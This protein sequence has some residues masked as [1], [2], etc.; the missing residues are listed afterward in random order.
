MPQDGGDHKNDL[1]PGVLFSLPPSGAEWGGAGG[2]H[3]L[4]APGDANEEI[5]PV[6]ARAADSNSRC[7]VSGCSVPA[8]NADLG[9]RWRQCRPLPLNRPCP[10]R[11][12]KLSY[13]SLNCLPAGSGS[14]LILR[15]VDWL[16]AIDG[17]AA[18]VSTYR[19]NRQISRPG[20]TRHGEASVA[21]PVLQG[22]MLA[23]A[24][25]LVLRR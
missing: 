10:C 6:Y 5:M 24:P 21:A 22:R 20:G 15:T 25:P 13:R 23:S 12:G 8:P 17:S 7:S 3:G 19:R 11:T 14:V 9:R 2:P 1:Y 4:A 18:I 16:R